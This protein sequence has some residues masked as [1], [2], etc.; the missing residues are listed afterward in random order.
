MLVR[1]RYKIFASRKLPNGVLVGIEF[2]TELE[3]I[4]ADPGELHKSA[5]NSTMQDVKKGCKKDPAVKSVW[6]ALVDGLKQERKIS[7][8]EEKLSE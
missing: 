7:A 5:Y 3:E 1:K 2:G 4:D 6:A 8:A